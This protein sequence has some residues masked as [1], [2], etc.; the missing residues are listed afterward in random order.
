MKM[1]AKSMLLTLALA[2]PA[3]AVSEHRAA[4]QGTSPQA[5]YELLSQDYY[6][7]EVSTATVDTSVS[8]KLEDG[9]WL[10][11][12]WTRHTETACP[13]ANPQ[14]TSGVTQTVAAGVAGNVGWEAGFVVGTA[15][16]GAAVSLI[17]ATAGT[18]TTAIGLGV[19]A[20]GP[21]VGAVVVAGIAIY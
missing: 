16:A 11:G 7:T 1:I 17:P 10:G 13:C 4:T 5:V 2:S 14:L 15:A 3:T 19:L 12:N 20:V 18:A 6:S 8:F 21:W 9:T